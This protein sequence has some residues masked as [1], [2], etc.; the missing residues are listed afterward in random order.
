VRTRQGEDRELAPVESG[1]DAL[2]T[3]RWIAVIR[4]AVVT[5]VIAIYLGSRLEPWPPGPLAVGVLV[6]AI[7]YSAWSLAAFAGPTEPSLAARMLSLLVDLALVTAWVLVTDGAMSDYWALYLVVLISAGM[8]FDLAQ[9]MGVAVGLTVLYGTLVLADGGLPR[10]IVFHRTSLF[11]IT[12][13]AVGVLSQQRLEHR[14]RG[15]A[16]W[17]ESQERGRLLTDERAEVERLKRVD[18]AKSEF[19]AVAAHEFRTPLAAVIGVLSTLREHGSVLT[20]EERIELLDGA[21]SQANRLARL[22]DDL[23]TVSRIEDGILRLSLEPVDPRNLLSEAAQVSGMSGR[24][25]IQMGR[26]GKVRCDQDAIIRVLTNLLDNARK[27]APPDSKVHIAVA[28]EGDLVRF[29]VADEGPGIPEEERREVFERFRRLDGGRTKPGAGLG[30]YICRG[31]VEAH[32][33]T[34]R[35]DEGPQGGA[36]FTFTLPRATKADEEAVAPPPPALPLPLVTAP[37]ADTPD[38]PAPTPVEAPAAGPAD[39]AVEVPA[40]VEELPPAAV[41]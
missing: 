13:F 4:L 12:G 17:E 35:V 40:A 28:V 34:I 16:L 3:E 10:E 38:V 36:E 15:Q 1:F 30:L 21:T 8:R 22:V 9:T 7:V 29:R 33:G 18:V 37:G 41:R 23:L 27:Y 5:V 39:I 32:G 6:L 19:V 25:V 11:I 20:P 24:L 26:V 14:R 31:L 2:R